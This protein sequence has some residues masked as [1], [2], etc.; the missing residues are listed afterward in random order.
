[1]KISE[2][3]AKDI[4]NM[5]NGKRLGQLNDLEI[6]LDTGKIEA[7]IIGHGG[8]VMS[9]FQQKD[10]EVVIPW[11]NIIKIGSDVILVEVPARYQAE[12]AMRENTLK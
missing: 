9:F 8:K 1:M 7:L 10:G 4:V 6:N 11:K 5:E 3:S 12:V 2:L